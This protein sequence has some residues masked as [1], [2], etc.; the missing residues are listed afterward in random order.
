MILNCNVLHQIEAEKI[1]TMAPNEPTGSKNTD[2]NSEFG[3]RS[4][5][6]AT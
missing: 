6:E 4:F 1:P 2:L 3:E 5:G